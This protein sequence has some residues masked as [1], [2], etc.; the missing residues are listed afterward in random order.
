[1]WQVLAHVQKGTIRLIKQQRKFSAY[2]KYI[3]HSHRV[4]W[5]KNLL[6]ALIQFWNKYK[7]FNAPP[8]YEALEIMCKL[9]FQVLECLLLQLAFINGI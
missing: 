9:Q 1:M 5:L 8:C 4:V 7:H 2:I 6:V 3:I